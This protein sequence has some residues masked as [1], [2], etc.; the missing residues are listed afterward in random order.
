[1]EKCAHG[2]SRGAAALHPL[3]ACIQARPMSWVHATTHPRSVP[4]AVAMVLRLTDTKGAVYWI[5][6]LLRTCS[7]AGIRQ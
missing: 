3:Q 4:K 1:M 6:A 7:A 2:R 5:S